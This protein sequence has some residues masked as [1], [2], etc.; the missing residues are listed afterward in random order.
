MPRS[1]QPKPKCASKKKLGNIDE[2][3]EKYNTD[4]NKEKIIVDL[5]KQAISDVF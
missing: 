2:N 1:S 5:L 3:Y 4:L